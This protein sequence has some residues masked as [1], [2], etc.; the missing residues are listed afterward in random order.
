MSK[1]IDKII[2]ITNGKDIDDNTHKIIQ[3]NK[4]NMVNDQY[5][6][7]IDINDILVPDP[8]YKPTVKHIKSVLKRFGCHIGGLK[9][10]LIQRLKSHVILHCNAIHIQRI[11]RGWVIN[12]T[13]KLFKVFETAR[14]KC[15]NDT[16]FY[17][18]DKLDDIPKFKFISVAD[19]DNHTYGFSLKSLY[20]LSKQHPMKN[21][22][23]RL[24]ISDVVSKQISWIYKMDH[25]TR[26]NQDPEELEYNPSAYEVYTRRVVTLFQFINQLGNYS[27]PTWF[28]ELSLFKLRRFYRNLRDIWYYRAGITWSTRHAISPSIDPFT[29]DI[30]EALAN[31]PDMASWEIVFKVKILHILELMVYTGIDTD[32]KTLGA[33]YIL[34]ALTIVSDVAATA[35]PWLYQSVNE[36]IY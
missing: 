12:R 22:Y 10:D 28:L 3:K 21:P 2:Q 8:N 4:M 30:N 20:I 13:Y 29:I 6:M 32:S 14:G 35:F 11:Y 33:L 34:S 9:N 7:W 25:F 31:T 19:E 16:D 5:Q 36:A 23:T 24:P 15:V 27:N 1:F 17:N 18:L 26:I